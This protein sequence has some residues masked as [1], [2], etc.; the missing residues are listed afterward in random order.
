M[1]NNKKQSKLA[2]ALVALATPRLS[3]YIPH[4]PTPRQAAFL[5]VQAREA[6]YGGAAGG[7]KSDALMMAALQYVDVPGYA[8]LLVRETFQMLA[9]PGGLISRSHEWLDATDAI[10]NGADHQWRF[11]S[12]A[13]LTFR[14]LNDAGAERNFQGAEYHFIGVDE[15]TDLTEFEYRFLFSRLRRLHDSDIPLRMRAASNPYGPGL[16]WCNRRFVLGAGRRGR[17]FIP[18]RLEDN[19]HLDQES[20]EESLRELG[21]VVYE[22]L[23]HGDWSVRQEGGLFRAEWFEER[24]IARSELPARL[25]LC[26]SWDLASSEPRLGNDPDYTAGVLLG[27][28][29]D[30]IY[31]LIDICRARSSPLKVE[32]LVKRTAERDA[33][34]AKERGFDRLRILMEEEPGSS[35]ASVT[36]HYRRDV[37]DGY[38]FHAERVTGSKESR[39]TPV[40][41]R[42]EAGDILVCRAPWNDAFLDEVVAF[43]EGRHDD[44]VDALSAALG[45][46]AK[47]KQRRIVSPISLTKESYWAMG[48]ELAWTPIGWDSYT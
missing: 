26:R 2:P 28:D 6:F 47:K 9:Q 41:A 22:Q 8:A 30:G 44:Q 45:Y 29:R 43:P 38:D 14:H 1:A 20:Y 46:L 33:E 42:A 32:R 39:A 35:G 11:P 13:T 4:H 36:S 24:M 40:A 21:P 5:L 31:Y 12:G 48:G 16:E 27:R 7:G 25:Q 23:R 17:I 19:P 34:W 3:R 37:L 10:W 15:V 18:A